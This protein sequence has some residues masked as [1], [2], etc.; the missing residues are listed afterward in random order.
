MAKTINDITKRETAKAREM[1][2]NHIVSLW[3]A[4]EEIRKSGKFNMVMDGEAVSQQLGLTKEQYAKFLNEY[5]RVKQIIIRLETVK[6][7]VYGK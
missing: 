5:G 3:Y 2:A 4:Y 1:S 6:A 7:S